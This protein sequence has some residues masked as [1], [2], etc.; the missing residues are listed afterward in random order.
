MGDRNQNINPHSSTSIEKISY[1]FPKAKC[2]ELKRSYRSS[3]EIVEFSRKINPG[4]SVLPVERHGE[5]VTVHKLLSLKEEVNYLK[6]IICNSDRRNRSLAILCKSEH[7]ARSL[8]RNLKEV[9]QSIHLLTFTDRK[10]VD[11]IIITSVHMAKG[12]EFDEVIIPMT[13]ED[14]YQSE[15]DRNLLYVA[16]TRAMHKLTVTYTKEPCDFLKE[17]IK[18]SK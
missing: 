18:K 4:S 5:E 7:Q 8:Y 15:M 16:C 1:I 17:Y 10:F 12:L 9:D 11:G 14:N 6:E 3:Y 2:M 13:N